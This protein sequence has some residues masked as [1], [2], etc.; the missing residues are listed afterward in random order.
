MILVSALLFSAQ[1]TALT[2]ISKL[3]LQ[4]LDQLDVV[5]LGVFGAE[6]LLVDLFPCLVLGLALHKYD[7]SVSA[8]S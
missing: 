2:L 5:L 3:I 6:V 8:Q 4:L 7:E 1:S